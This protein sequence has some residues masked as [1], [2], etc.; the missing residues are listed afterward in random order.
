MP[1]P[2]EANTVCSELKGWSDFN[3]SVTLHELSLQTEMA[4][5]EPFISQEN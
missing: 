2:W 5:G 1:L 4:K 3:P